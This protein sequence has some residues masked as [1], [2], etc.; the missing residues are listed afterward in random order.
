MS[1]ISEISDRGAVV[2][3]SP[4][5]GHADVIALGSKEKGGAGFDDYGG[6]LELYDV[7]LTYAAGS[8]APSLLS[9]VKT[10]TRFGS[11]AWGSTGHDGG[12]LAG[13]MMDGTVNLWSS[14]TLLNGG[15]GDAAAM[16]AS[17]K[18]HEGVVSALKFN[19]HEDSRHFLA[20]GGGTGHVLIL[21]IEN[22][23]LP[24]VY[25]PS[26]EP[27]SQNATITQTAWNSQVH[28]ILASSSASGT[29]V[30]WDLRQKK[31]W[32]EIRC[33]SASGVT[34]LAWNPT[35]GLHMMTAGEN[36]GLKL[37]DLRASTTMPL[38]T[39]E[40]HPGGV[41]SLDWCPHDDT[42]LLSCGKDNRTLLWDL[43]SLQPIA[44]IPNEESAG[45]VSSS[46]PNDFYGGGLVSSQQKRYHVQW[47][48]IRRGVVSTCSFDRK[49]QV[50]SVVGL[51]TKCGRPPKW[52][53]PSSGVSCGFGGVVVAINSSQKYLMIDNIIEHPEL[54]Q[55][56]EQL[57]SEFSPSDCI[58]YCRTMAERAA[59]EYESHVWSFMQIM[60]ETNAREELLSYLG[61]DPDKI[62]QA[63]MEF[64]EDG[65]GGD[66]EPTPAMSREAENAVKDALLV[67][68]FEAAVECCFRSGNLADA[69]VLA[70]CGGA[71][72]WAKTQ[73]EYF[74]REAK[75]RP[76]L[77]LVSA[78]IHNQL[79]DL[80]SLSD[81][82][83]WKE[84]L[85]VLSTYGKSEEF[86]MLCAALGD[87]LEEVGDM[88]NASLCYMCALNLG[89][90]AKYWKRTLHDA[91]A[92]FGGTDLISLHEFIE[93]VTVFTQAMDSNNE[94]DDETANLFAAYSSA[95]A[96]QGL[97]VA[98]AKYLKGNTKECNELRD[99]IYRSRMGQF[100]PDLIASPPEFPYDYVNVGVARDLYGVTVK[101][102]GADVVQ[103]Q[104]QVIEPQPV[105]VVQQQQ[106][107]QQQTAQ[108]EQSRVQQQQQQYQR[109]TTPSL[110]PGWVALQDPSSGMTYYA[111][112]DTGESSWDPPQPV[113]PKPETVLTSSHENANT[114]QPSANGTASAGVL[115]T[116]KVANKYGDGFVTSA[117]NPRLAEQYGNIGTRL[118]NSDSHLFCGWR[119]SRQMY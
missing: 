87:R 64:S 116:Q 40:G 51:A 83:K 81:P 105:N 112:Q 58:S 117:S 13:G 14:R 63:A 33:E 18:R 32:C 73:A 20:S 28:H 54:V 103:H 82:M 61:F 90:T 93:K 57:E 106:P 84:T 24:N 89:Q 59:N 109:P 71:D 46:N 92:S 30:V 44:E 48:P 2:A 69:L 95:L 11:I 1:L 98:A 62:H 37:W 99:R 53:S 17:E 101:Q 49:V 72:L 102:N 29:V 7:H 75:K 80:V 52:M 45:L 35:Q 114:S 118:E 67:G 42:L 96:N 25:S 86:P 88:A 5:R 91:N 4:V 39:L 110:P 47:S 8:K 107:Q 104:D 43:Y 97:L 66:G 50:H 36:G 31:P 15:A 65:S 76:F 3:W 9:S 79:T 56:S 10:T 34:D 16:L 113:A 74:A 22:P 12:I 60:F 26:S 23:S 85:A 108:Q 70:S 38:T 55:V 115:K 19:P 41:L 111:N 94:L 119:F 21:D 6:E 27:S 77:S 100:C 68:N 78:V